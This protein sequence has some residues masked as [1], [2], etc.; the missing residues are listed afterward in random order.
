LS[1]VLWAA[2]NGGGFQESKLAWGFL[3]ALIKKAIIS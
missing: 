2:D 1:E 3:V